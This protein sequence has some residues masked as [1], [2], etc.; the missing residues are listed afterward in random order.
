ML[1][2]GGPVSPPTLTYVNGVGP[3]IPVSHKQVE[4]EHSQA[5]NKGKA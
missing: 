5:K 4:C 1:D 3:T 2:S